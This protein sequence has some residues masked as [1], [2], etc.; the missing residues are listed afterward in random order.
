MQI[1]EMSID[2]EDSYAHCYQVTRQIPYIS[3]SLEDMQVKN[4][5][6]NRLLYYTGYVGSTTV[7]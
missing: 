5:K 4:V 6:H 3:F 7:N 1:A 2:E